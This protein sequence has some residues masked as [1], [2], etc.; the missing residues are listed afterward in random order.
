M[1]SSTKR[2]SFVILKKIPTLLNRLYEPKCKRKADGKVYP[3]IIKNKDA[4][5]FAEYLRL[6][7][8]RQKCINIMEGDVAMKVDFCFRGKRDK[9]IDSILKLLLDT[10]NGIMYKDDKQIIDLHIRKHRDQEEDEI[11]VLVE[12]IKV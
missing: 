7:A 8:M 5:K 11:V 4:N 6:E 12:E 2:Q 10:L 3:T 1:K 9:D